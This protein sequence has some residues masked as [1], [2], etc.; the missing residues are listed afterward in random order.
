MSKALRGLDRTIFILLALVLIVL[1]IWPI[2]MYFNVTFATELARWVQHDVWAGIPEQSWYIYVLIATGIIALFLGL[3]LTITNV[4]SHR[5]NAVESAVSDDAGSVTTLF[6]S[7]GQ[8]IAQSL[9][10]QPGIQ[11]AKSKVSVIEK[12]QTLTFTVL[13]QATTELTDVR[14]LVEETERDFRA[15]FPDAAV[16]TVYNLH[17]DKVS[18]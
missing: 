13:A 16:R 7:A 3:W 12:Q 6:N 8:G 15:A 1:G 4:R 2:L 17:F 10:Q 11:S 14:R 5:F 9:A 18:K